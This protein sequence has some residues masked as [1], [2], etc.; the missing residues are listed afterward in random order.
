MSTS[1]EFYQKQTAQFIKKWSKRR[2]N[3]VRFSL[4]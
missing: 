3:K 2:L 1:N 4:L